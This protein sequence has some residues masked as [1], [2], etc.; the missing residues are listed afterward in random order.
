MRFLALNNS[1]RPSVSAAAKHA[2]GLL[3]GDVSLLGAAA[4][5]HVH[6]WNR[7]SAAEDAGVALL[8]AGAQPAARAQFDHA[9]QTYTR[10]GA[11]RDAARLRTRL[12]ALGRRQTTRRS[13]D[14]PTFG[15]ESLTNTEHRVVELV[16]DGLTNKQVAAE[17]FLSRHTV[18]FHLRRAFRKLAVR[19]RVQLTRLA[20]D[21]LAPGL[22]EGGDLELAVLRPE[23]R[24][25]LKEVPLRYRRAGRYRA[26]PN[27]EE[28]A[29]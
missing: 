12:R 26:G 20:L 11:E 16:A 14:R 29:F 21:R 18:D 4:S 13:A 19:S 5:E 17:M 25:E 24:V 15:W 9:L 10:V 22:T 6:P 27:G 8:D 7:A 3:T 2:Q 28:P 1:G 23:R